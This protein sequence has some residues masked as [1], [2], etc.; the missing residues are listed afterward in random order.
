[1]LHCKRRLDLELDAMPPL[2]LPPGDLI[3][4][5]DLGTTN[6]EV[7]VVGSDGQ[8]HVLEEDGNPILPSFVGLSEDGRLLVGKA[9]R[10]QWV[11]APERTVK[12]V[13]RSMGQDVKVKL[14]ERDYRPQEISAMI[15][16]KLKDRAERALERPVS[17][18]VITVP[19]YFNDAQRQAT[20]EAGEL[21]GLEVV[22]ILNEPTAASLTY[23]PSHMQLQ[24]ML[25][26]DLGGGTFDVSLVQAQESV[27]EVL[28]SHGDTQLGG[29]DFDDLLLKHVCDRF[30]TEHGVDLRANLVAKSR[31]LQAVEAAKRQLS[32]HPVA[33]IEEEFI[34]EKNGTALHLN[35]EITREL[36]ESLIH[37]LLDRTIDC[38]QRSLDDA[39]LNPSQ[40]EKVVL[41][42]GSTR[43][44]LVSQ[45]LQERLGQ[46]AHQEVNPDLCVAMGAAIQAAIIAGRNVG[47]VLV[48]IT[49]HSLGIKC[50]SE[51]HGFEFP[52]Q[53]APIIQR[54]APLP[55][56]RSEMFY[57][58]YDRQTEVEID[59]YQGE[60]EDVR[61]NHRVGRFLIQGLALVAAGNQIVVQLD[62]N[63]DGILKVS[64]RE[65]ATG[66][67]KQVTIEN[68]LARYEREELDEARERLQDLWDESN[69]GREESAELP[70]LVPGP[71]EGQREAVQARALLE[72]AE[73][74]LERVS[75][76]DREDVERLMSGVRTAL[77]D[78]HWDR[79]TTASNELA[80]ALFYLEG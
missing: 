33:R 38:L 45:M 9:A 57:T 7:A 22:R 72:K 36:Y 70:S 31:L 49:P 51:R 8:P 63:L 53:F 26:Y 15:L 24:R 1:L 47:A 56:S 32:F 73:R 18:A 21:A 79:V 50:L 68:A 60:S 30:Q 37:P 61:H 64:A 4:G 2:A 35:L 6:S 39:R 54:N 80:D 25:V 66:L 16:R 67:Q 40:I 69:N 43:T 71:R 17:R 34:A 3:V 76:E 74:L 13:K 11:L 48:D 62:L 44:P 14:G 10:N 59:V 28:A 46:L 20:R 19:A 52:F 23:D 75:P 41:V 27:V 55:A 77:S 29:D 78:R 5:I 58:I 42:G 65:R 12:S